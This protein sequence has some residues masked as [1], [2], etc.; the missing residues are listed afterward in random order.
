[1]TVTNTAAPILSGTAKQGQTLVTS[2]GTWTYDLD[3]LTYAY[4]WL[5]CDANGQNCVA[6]DGE[7]TSRLFL[8]A[9]DVGYRIR[10][11]VTATEHAGTVPADP[12]DW[13]GPVTINSGGTYVGS[14]ESTDSTPAVTIATTDPIVLS[15]R[16]RN[17]VGPGTGY[18]IDAYHSLP[19][20]DIDV[21]IENMQVF[22]G[23]TYQ[24]SPRWF[25][26]QNFANLVI[27]NCTIENT[28]GIE[29]WPTSTV[30]ATVLITKNRHHNIVGGASEAG[31]SYV[32][33]FVQFRVI[34]GADIEVSWNE[35]ENEYNKSE[36]EDIISKI[37]RA[38]V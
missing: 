34:R 18:I 29:L 32:G 11:E 14:W 8:R 21:T 19:G 38:H 7:T 26:A 36:P 13:Q 9:A 20:G 15:G 6:I 35:I 5:R 37:G 10:S 31:L 2:N 3:Y 24:T 33:N 30:G 27:R 4:R 28:R 22:G 16:V 1:M 17:L 25:V 23:T 12:G